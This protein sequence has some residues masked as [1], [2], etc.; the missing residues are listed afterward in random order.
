M[1]EL[2]RR[3]LRTRRITISSEDRFL[4]RLTDRPGTVSVGEAGE[5]CL[6]LSRRQRMIRHSEKAARLVDVDLAAMLSRGYADQQ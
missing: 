4:L 1:I 5:R 3:L 6:H 2:V